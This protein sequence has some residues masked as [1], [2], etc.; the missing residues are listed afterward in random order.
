MICVTSDIHGYPLPDFLRL[1]KKARFS[2]A[3]DLIVQGDVINR[4]GGRR[5]AHAASTGG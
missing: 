2:D 3:D 1:L 4:N 5:R